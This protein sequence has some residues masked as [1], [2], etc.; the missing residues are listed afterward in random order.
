MKVLVT[1]SKGQLGSEIAFLS[2]T[3]QHS[4]IFSDIEEM[5]LTKKESILTY[6]NSNTPDFI[7]S[8]G[9]YTAVDK[10]EDETELAHKVNAIAPQ[11]L[12]E[13]CVEHKTRLI[14]VSTDYVFDGASNTPMS[15]EDATNPQ[16][17]YGQTKLDGEKAILRLLSNAYIVRT[18]WVYSEF[19]SNFVKTMLRVGSERDEI[20]VVND[21]V[22][23]PT[24]ARDLAEAI[25][26]IVN[27]IIS[28]NDHPGVYH[29]SN[30]G[31]CSWYDFAKEIF[32][33]KGITCKINPIPTSAY[34]T[35]ANRPNYSVFDK[36]KIKNTF[37]VSVPTWS[38]SLVNCLKNIN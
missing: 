4:F 16:S 6:L 36:S 28:G 5:D 17:V 13:Y 31:V 38:D 10:A 7:I 12:A 33:Q 34:P 9:A 22:G 18:S 3:S 26:K 27:E 37:D 2:S 14:H 32:E 8:C 19:G 24:Y 23:T 25:L 15:E 35:K 11:I 20:S 21:Q 30:E 1:G 29:F